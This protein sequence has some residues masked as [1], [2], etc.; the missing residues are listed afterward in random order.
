MV[1]SEET[2]NPLD[3][4]KFFKELQS[5]LVRIKNANDTYVCSANKSYTCTDRYISH[6]NF[7]GVS[8]T[9]SSKGFPIFPSSLTIAKYT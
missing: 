9:V 8:P 6:P 7:L 4:D 3:N 2:T 1:S 5:Y